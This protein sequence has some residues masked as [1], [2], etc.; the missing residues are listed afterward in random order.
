MTINEQGILTISE[1][2]S[3]TNDGELDNSGTL[4]IEAGGFLTNCP[5]QLCSGLLYGGGELFNSGTL[6]P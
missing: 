5:G 3:L 6:I 1:G 4:T 2:G